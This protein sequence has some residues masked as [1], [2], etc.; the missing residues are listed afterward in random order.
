MN[1]KNPP[2]KNFSALDKLTTET[3]GK[4]P[5]ETYNQTAALITAV[6]NLSYTW[7]WKYYWIIAA[8]LLLTIPLSIAA[9]GLFRWSIRS[10]ARYVVYWRVMVILFGVLLTLTIYIIIPKFSGVVGMMVSIVLHMAV[11]S[12]YS[13]WRLYQAYHRRQ[14]RLIWT[15]F[16]FVSLFSIVFIW[17]VLFWSRI[18]LELI[19]WFYLLLVW[20]RQDIKTWWRDNLFYLLLVWA[21]QNIKTWWRGRK[22]RSSS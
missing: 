15:G 3:I 19:P 9:G 5:V 8:A 14:D 10:A 1:I 13:V 22:Q 2:P 11:L 16:F 20:A 4:F 6:N 17:F 18:V 21:R 7:E 12:A